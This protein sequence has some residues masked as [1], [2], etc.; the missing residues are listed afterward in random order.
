MLCLILAYNFSVIIIQSTENTHMFI[1]LFIY[2]F[3]FLIFCIFHF[4]IYFVF[5]FYFF[6]VL[7]I[8]FSKAHFTIRSFSLCYLSNKTVFLLLKYTLYPKLWRYKIHDLETKSST[9][10]NT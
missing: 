5:F 9:L 10:Y 3:F 4:L 6:I 7:T 8:Y 2:L 1:H